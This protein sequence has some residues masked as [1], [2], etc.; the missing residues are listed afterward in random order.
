MKR[1]TI[2]LAGLAAAIMT[3]ACSGCSAGRQGEIEYIPPETERYENCMEIEGQWGAN[4]AT[5]PDGQYGI[6]DPFVMRYN[7]KYYLYPSTSDPCDGIKVFESDDMIHWT[8]RGFAVAESEITS[9]G[10]Y[11]PEVVYYNG[12]FY[13]CQSRGGQGHYIYR[14]ESPTEGF[15]LFS[16]SEEG[17]EG[18]IGFGNLGMGI[19]GSFFVDDDGKIYLM[20]TSTPAGLKINEI[21]DVD[22][23]RPSTIGETQ[24]LGNANLRH[25]IEGPGIFR[26][27]DYRYLTYTGNHVIS[28]GYRVAYS[29]APDGSGFSDFI[30][31]LD[32]VTLIDTSPEHYGLGHSSNFN[33][34]DLDSVYTAYHSLVGSGPARRYN[35]DRY[36]ASGSILAANGVTHRPVAVPSRPTA[37][38][39]DAS[40]LSACGGGYSLG[41]TEE[42]FTAEYNF[43]PEEGQ[44][45]FFGRTQEGDWRIRLTQAGIELVRVQ[46]GKETLVSRAEVKYPEDKLNTVRVENGDGVGY[47]YLNGMRLI[48]YQAEAAAGD[49][50]Y[51]LKGGV[52]YTAFTNDVFGT[53]DFEAIKNFP[54]EFPA[55]DYLKGENR[56]FSIL[57]AKQETGGVRVGEKQAVRLVEDAYAVRLTARGD[58]VKYAVDVPQDGMY[59]LSVRVAGGTDARL[60]ITIGESVL[61]CDVKADCAEE[62]SV[63]LSLGRIFLAGGVQSMKVEIVRG[64]ADLIAFE[65]FENAADPGAAEL[66]EFVAESGAVGLRSGELVVS[67]GTEP[68]AALWGNAGVSDFKAEIT[69]RC[70]ISEN[71]E[72]GIMI[73]ADHYSWF[74]AQPVQSWRGYYLSLGSMIVTLSRYDYGEEIMTAVRSETLADGGTHVVGITAKS[75]RIIVTLDGELLLEA[76]DRCAFLSGRLGI[77]ALKGEIDVLNVKYEII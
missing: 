25:W 47:V 27:G 54:T 3:N 63:R 73:R 70:A 1:S 50:G 4:P 37:E 28:E 77:Y 38:A 65:S 20:H 60:K 22:D 69:F 29:Y 5:G 15:T 72:L 13:L 55:I 10:A 33:G 48:S 44:E 9:H 14:S 74:S 26:R 45:L 31:P 42:A 61:E 56:G 30:Q 12:Y 67:G 39:E 24:D 49:L 71:S 40:G 16:R 76:T 53:S 58:W 35:L 19:D 66:S 62:E 57:G 17:D 2:V 51:S 36:F 23:I 34:P 18:D 41:K 11:A 59:S 46:G 64:S 68:G 52:C 8:Y 7:G 6:G 32:N 21:T 43:I 75:N